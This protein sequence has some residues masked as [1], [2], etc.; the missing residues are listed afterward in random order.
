VRNEEAAR[1]A[2]WAATAAG[3]VALLVAGFYVV[4]AVRA[5]RRHARP[6]QVSASVEQQMQTFSYSGMEGNRTIFTIRASRATEFRAGRPALLEDVWISI[7]GRNQDRNDSIHTRECSY[8]E[9]TG[10]VQCAGEVTIDIRAAKPQPG[11]A[12]QE[13]AHLTTSNLTF[14]GQT[15][16]ARTPAAVEFTLP[17]GRGSGVGVTYR[18]RAAIVRVEHAVKF[19]MAP[20]ARNGGFPVSI[21]AASLEVRRNDRKVFLAG[22]VVVRQDDRQLSAGGVVV[23]LGEKFHARQVLAQGEPKIRIARGA[24]LLR[25]SATKLEADLSQDGWIEHL[26]ASGDVF[27]SRQS[28]KGSSRFASDRADFAMLPTRNLLREMTATGSVVAASE[29]GALSQTLNAPALRVG[30]ASGTRPDQQR[31]Q[32]AET[33]GPSTIDLKDKRETTELRAPKFTAQFTNAGRL[34]RLVGETGVDV[35]R[36]SEKAAPQVSTAQALDASFTRDG[37]WS[38]V[39]ENGGVTFQQGD[40]RATAQ[41][42]RIDRTSGEIML[43]GAPAIE[44]ALSRTTAS[45]VAVAQ[46]SGEFAAEG[47]VM[48]TYFPANGQ[49]SPKAGTEAAHIT[50]EKLTGSSTSGRAVYSGHAR[51]WQGESVLQADQI[52]VVREQK[53]LQA[54]GNVTAVFEQTS[55]AGLL[56]LSEPK[57]A[58]PTL[59]QAR[60]PELTYS[61]DEG[62]VHLAGGVRIV[63]GDVSLASRTL[64]LDLGASKPAG[65]AASSPLGSGQLNR[66]IARG[67]VVVR[68]GELR[69]TAEQAVYTAADGKFVLSGGKPTITDAS[70]NSASGRSL[71]FFLPNDTILIDS[72]E[73]SRTLSR[74]RVEK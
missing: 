36:T 51:L 26:T 43:T 44:D 49:K 32:S 3:L 31:I 56:P 5:A 37:Q 11:A 39:E 10:G 74:Y 14:D 52:E 38:V 50:A 9:K 45:T 70:G 12:D 60:A 68:Q 67:D 23:S 46:K 8:E 48:T 27:G 35:R 28:P 41:H 63:S 69:A 42:A 19:E 25:A 22:P 16:E 6:A 17:Q 34:E 66:A 47:G 7:Y 4:R 18:T 40:R 54:T 61:G 24:D 58:G 29:Q 30:L 2:R 53:K 62:Q 59:W 15:G 72:Q 57:K 20:T 13:S 64:D 33:L 73:G 1:Y 65:A 55:G 21:Q 71:T